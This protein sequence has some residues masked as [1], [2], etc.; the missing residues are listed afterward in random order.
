MNINSTANEDL[1]KITTKEQLRKYLD[2][3]YLKLKN[4]ESLE[5]HQ[6]TLGGGPKKNNQQ[7]F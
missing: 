1:N 2:N 7:D 4:G 6:R 5:I 3:A